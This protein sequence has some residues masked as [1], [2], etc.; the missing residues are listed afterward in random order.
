MKVTKVDMNTEMFVHRKCNNGYH[1]AQAEGS[2]SNSVCK[3]ATD[4]DTD[5]G[6][7]LQITML[8]CDQTLL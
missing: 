4:S 5:H 6:M 7:N 2:D 8:Y 1:C 3:S